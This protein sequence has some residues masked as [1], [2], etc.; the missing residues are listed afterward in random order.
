[1]LCWS[2]RDDFIVTAGSDFV[3]RVWSSLSGSELRQLVGHKEDA[4]VLHSHP[5][6]EDYILS[7]GHDGF[8]MDLGMELFFDFAISP[9][10]T[11]VGAVDSHGHLS[12]LGI[13]TNQ[14]AKTTPKE[15]FF[16][17]DYMPLILDEN[18]YFVDEETEIAPHLMGPPRMVDADGV[19]YDDDIQALVPG[20]DLLLRDDSLIPQ[21]PPWLL[22]QMVCMLPKSAVEIKICI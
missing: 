14:M 5:I 13:G 1:M 9:D 11:L 8:L 17:T 21:N 7:G 10:G 15:Q 12:I 2:L 4:Y 3:L 16:H 20:R 18:N 19:D 22:R 6:F